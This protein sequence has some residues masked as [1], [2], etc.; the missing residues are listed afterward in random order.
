MSDTRMLLQKITALRQRLEQ[1]QGL[2]NEARSAAAELLAGGEHDLALDAAVRPVA[3]SGDLDARAPRQLTSRARRVLEHGRHLL[4]Q[5]RGLAETFSTAQ[6][7][8]KPLP[9]TNLYRDTAWM[10]DTALRTV[11]LLPE[12][13]TAQMHLCR[14]LEVTLEE[15]ASRVHTLTS[16]DGRLHYQE[17]QIAC[18]AGLLQMVDGGQPADVD[19]LRALADQILTE[20][21]E[22]EPLHF[23]Q[24]DLPTDLV[25]SDARSHV[26]RFVAC[27]SI[28][29]ARVVA[30][31]VRY[32]AEMRSRAQEAVLAA[33]LHDV[34]MLGVPAEVL[35]Y[36]DTLEGEYR[37]LIEGHVI[38]GAQ[39][40][41]ALFPD[42][43]GVAEAIAGHH[44][45]MDGT[46]YP[47]GLKGNS[48][49]PMAR[50]LAI[51]DVYSAFCVARPHRPARP[52]R[53]AL[54]D[55]LLLTE[56]GQFD[57]HFAECLLSLS[58]YPVGSVVELAHGAV[59]VVV[60]TPRATADVNSLTRPVVA[61]LTDSQGEPLA[62][63]HHVD[64]SQ[65]DSH[66]I[67]RLLS[68]AERLDLLG[69]RFPQ[70]AA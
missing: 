20:A 8:D 35:A 26:E 24:G 21:R 51:C 27:H 30:R 52:T 13:A 6:P 32:D 60:A 1:A 65:T 5:L 17:E 2:A 37:R 63:P 16:Y 46:G 43:P 45:R 53:T 49:R 34:G 9:L 56:Q 59:G 14:G 40:V 39:Q 54:A 4:E 23:L 57:H 55:T 29:V 50:L 47:D 3:G 62:R 38:V 66:S 70:W 31:V 12:T 67:V 68:P 58:F 69:R 41:A 15:V 28:T 11:S 10:I 61:L 36:P 19:L 33:L 18:L 64:L 42:L 7:A 48:I 25:G 44:E 22:C